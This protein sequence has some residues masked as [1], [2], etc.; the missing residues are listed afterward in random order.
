MVGFDQ[1]SNEIDDISTCEGGHYS[2]LPHSHP[3][4]DIFE[5]KIFWEPGGVRYAAIRKRARKTRCV[6]GKTGRVLGKSFPITLP[7]FRSRYYQNQNKSAK[8]SSIEEIS[9]VL[10]KFMFSWRKSNFMLVLVF[11]GLTNRQ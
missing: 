2:P 6:V 11:L 8:L 10:N 4:R 7:V 3:L 1:F 5:P 9:R